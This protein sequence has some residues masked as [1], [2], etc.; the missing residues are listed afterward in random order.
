MK[1]MARLHPL[2]AALSPILSPLSLAYGSLAYAKRALTRCGILKSAS[3]PGPCVSIG[4][5]SW[6][7]TGK[8][9][10]TDFLLSRAEEKG[11][12]AAVLTR[13][14]GSRPP[15]LPYSV[16]ASSPPGECGDE[17]LML[18]RSHPGSDV[19]VDP[20]RLRGGLSLASPPD[21]Y[22][23]DDGFQHVAVRRDLDLVLLDIEDVLFDAPA[24]NPSNWNRTIPRGSWREPVRALDDADAFLI[25]ASPEEWPDLVPALKTR[26]AGFPRPVFAF[27]MEA[28]GLSPVSDAAAGLPA[29]EGPYAFVSGIGSPG[30]AIRTA[31]AFLGRSPAER[32]DLPDHHDFSGEK[33]RLEQLALPIV[34]TAK[35]AVKLAKLRLSLPCW[36]L[37]VRAVFHASLSAGQIAG[38]AD[39]QTPPPPSF[40]TWW[41]EWQQAHIPAHT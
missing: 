14:Y 33:A 25:K 28:C 35:D 26:L 1:R 39:G 17:P 13:G 2:Q 19:V 5:I 8:T 36:S 4:N 22:I 40:D 9:P 21:F 38:T 27:R 30:Q 15:H 23:L 3:L 6:G 12:R 18:K 29:P 32:L 20:V 41:N 11:L 16:L 31:A 37:D 24:R 10:V 7:G 34:C